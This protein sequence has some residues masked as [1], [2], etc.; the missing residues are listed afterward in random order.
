MK[1]KLLSVRFT[2]ID[3]DS[4]NDLR[5]LAEVVRDLAADIESADINRLYDVAYACHNGTDYRVVPVPLSHGLI[6]EAV[7]AGR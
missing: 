3:V 1:R 7:I 5:R 2:F 4:S 6:A